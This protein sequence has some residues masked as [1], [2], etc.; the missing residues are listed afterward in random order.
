MYSVLILLTIIFVLYFLSIINSQN[1]FNVE[2][3]SRM[4]YLYIFDKN[5]YL[6][7]LDYLYAE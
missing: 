4:G 3:R 1:Q 7:Y 5:Y 2:Y 6:N